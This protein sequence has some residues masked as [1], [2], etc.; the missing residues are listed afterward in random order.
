MC[1]ETDIHDPSVYEIK[2][3]GRLDKRRSDWF[4]GM[5]MGLGKASDDTLITTLTGPV[6]DQ[7]RLRGI[8]SKLWDLNL[9]VI[10]VTSDEYIG[11]EDKGSTMHKEA[12]G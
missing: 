6:A 1:D 3:R 8:L 9:T 2:V 4:E 5:T 10:S 11:D 7:A 12:S